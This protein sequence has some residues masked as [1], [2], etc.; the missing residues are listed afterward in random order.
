MA[1][2]TV[3]PPPAVP[4]ERQLSQALQRCLLRQAGSSQHHHGGS[5]SSQRSH[6]ARSGSSRASPSHAAATVPLR[7]LQCWSA[8]TSSA[9]ARQRSA[10]PL[11]ASAGTATALQSSACPTAAQLVS[12]CRSKAQLSLDCGISI[13][14]SLPQQQRSAAAQQRQ[15]R[16]PSPAVATEAA[17]AARSAAADALSFAERCLSA[18]RRSSGGAARCPAPTPCTFRFAKSKGTLTHVPKPSIHHYTLSAGVLRGAWASKTSLRPPAPHLLPDYSPPNRAYPLA[19]DRS[20]VVTSPLIRSKDIT[21][22]CAVRSVP[23]C[24]VRLLI[25]GG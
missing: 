25:V 9:S 23:L 11:C 18:G 21:N 22:R 24:E 10:L 4:A 13:Y 2:P 20:T 16:Q 15:L 14:R 17:A 19:P 3:H 6:A 8:A 5:P 12:L 7:M 1:P